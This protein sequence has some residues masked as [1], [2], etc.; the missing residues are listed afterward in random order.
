M[1][2]LCSTKSRFTFQVLFDDL[3]AI[4]V[5]EYVQDDDVQLPAR[6]I[7]PLIELW[8]LKE[9]KD[10]NLVIDRTAEYIDQLR[11]FFQHIWFPWD[12]QDD[13]DKVD[14]ASQHL[15]NR[16]KFYC[17]LKN[18][19]MKSR[20]SSHITGLLTEARYL[21]TK[22]ELLEMETEGE[23]D[24]ELVKKA[25]VLATNLLKIHLRMNEIKNNI[26]ILESSD[27][28]M[29][30]IYDEVRFSNEKKYFPGSVPSNKGEKETFIVSLIGSMDHQIEY[31]SK[32][33]SFIG[34][35]KLVRIADSL[36]NVL[37]SCNGG[38]EIYIPPG[39]HLVKLPDDLSSD[40]SIRAI[41]SNR[42]LDDKVVAVDTP[43][44][45]AVICS[46]DDDCILLSI[47]GDC[48]FENI[49]FDCT[50][51]RN[52]VVVKAGNVSFKNCCFVGDPKPA[53]NKGLVL[54]GRYSTIKL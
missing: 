41:N 34:H 53:E 50:N 46:R 4:F 28:R 1:L 20:L 19:T 38:E 6:Q 14:W 51:V 31:L 18:K 5:V 30:E 9:Q 3:K 12:N 8:P 48:C 2:V 37:N 17:D 45:V 54:L 52:G 23:D 22:R 16:I 44:D 32:A 42:F 27:P 24:E 39:K 40:E 35:E 49:M 36:Q 29:R 10:E 33:K 21:Q 13:N 15:Q 26:D 43:E 11:F 47:A 25:E 7:V